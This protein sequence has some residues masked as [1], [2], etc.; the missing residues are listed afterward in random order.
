MKRNSDLI[1]QHILWRGLYFFSVLLINIGIARFFAAEKSGQIFYIINNL[2]LILLLVS[3]SLE[4]GAA[5]YIASG[6]LDAS[7]MARYCVFWAIAASFIALAGW[8]TILYFSHSHYLGEPEFLLTSFLFILGV[9]LTS[10]FTALFYAKKEFRLPNKTLFWINM[11]FLVMLVTGKNNAFIKSDFIQ[12]YF[13]CFFIQGLL[14]VIF[15]FRKYPYSDILTFPGG[16]QLNLVIRYSLTA[17]LA[18]LIYFLVYRM[19]YWL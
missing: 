13:S 16:S 19:D 2:A 5:F 10:Y 12:L 8:W 9:L 3:I 1:L 11:L 17:L 18:N 4:S 14:M 7:L 6:N 15:F